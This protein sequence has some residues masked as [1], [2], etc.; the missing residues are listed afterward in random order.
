M[1]SL[2]K[3]NVNAL[4]TIVDTPGVLLDRNL[5]RSR[6]RVF[7]IES[8]IDS[9]TRKISRHLET[10]L[11]GFIDAGNGTQIVCCLCLLSPLG[12]TICENF[13][14]FPQHVTSCP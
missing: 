7:S 9:P 14:L 10:A 5:N 13:R 6:F 1:F 8:R 2:E 12:C 4:Q 3:A 11:F